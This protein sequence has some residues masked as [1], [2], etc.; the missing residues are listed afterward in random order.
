MS[1]VFDKT[2]MCVNT[3][4]RRTNSRV[5]AYRNKSRR[6]DPRC[7]A[8][9]QVNEDILFACV[10]NDNNIIYSS[11]QNDKN[12]TTKHDYTLHKCH[13][14]VNDISYLYDF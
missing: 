10:F 13:D 11:S 7:G 4:N 2:S 3:V 14:Q 9:P 1:F 5:T 6:R 12:I 8:V